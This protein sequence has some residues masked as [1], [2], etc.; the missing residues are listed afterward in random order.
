MRLDMPPIHPLIDLAINSFITFFVI[1]DPLGLIGIFN[2]LAQGMSAKNKQRLAVRGTAV[3]SVVLLLFALGG[4]QLLSAVGISLPAFRAAGGILLLLIAI[5]MIF[6]NRA[7]RRKET[8]TKTAEEPPVDDL[9]IFPLA[10]PLIAGPG[11]ITSVLL[12]A[13]RYKGAYVEQGIV[14]TSMLVVLAIT[15]VT[16]LAATRLSHVIGPTI[17]SVATR[18]LGI[19]LAAVAVEYVVVGVRQIW[20]AAS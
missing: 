19:L 2:G 17:A 9:A 6:Q 8:A 15:L 13:S 20:D 1:I 12:L 14:L 18:L 5:E 7:E 16:F 3:G 11:A 4:Q 10:I